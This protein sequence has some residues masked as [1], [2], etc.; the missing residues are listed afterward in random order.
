VN[1]SKSNIYIRI[2]I[3]I[4]ASF[5]ACLIFYSFISLEPKCQITPGII[6]LVLLL[7]VIVLSESFDNFSVGKI[8]SLSR[9]NTKKETS[10]SKLNI[11]NNELRKDFRLYK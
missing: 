5:I 7:I 4:L 6:T 10:I 3:V 8:L 9:E 11:E 1:E 2:L